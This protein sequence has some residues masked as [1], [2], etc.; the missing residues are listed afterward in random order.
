MN[1]PSRRIAL[2]TGANKGIGFEIAHQIARSGATVL[3]GARDGERGK[4]AVDNLVGQGLDVALVRI[5]VTDAESVAAAASGIEAEYGRLD[6]LVN[7][8]GIA[9]F[10]DG[11]P[12]T[13]AIET[14]RRT[15]ETNFFGPLMIAQAMVPLLS[16]SAAGRIVNVSSSL[17]S[18]T[19]NGNPD[20]PVRF[21]G[22]NASKA[23]LNM[24]TVQLNAELKDKGII[25]NSICPGF[26]KTDLNG[27]TG[28][29]TPSEGASEAVRLA[30]QSDAAIA[31]AFR[32]A[33]GVVP[34]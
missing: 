19:L 3:L 13:T 24:L 2:V 29:L 32:N 18:L 31:G 20:L 16:K 11:D 28:H 9:D 15:F 4:A 6:I 34:W 30:L 22:Y 14:V 23:A 8:A 12:S 21:I 7:N 5:D 27:H 25:A 17:G 26:V 10:S 33:E 1:T